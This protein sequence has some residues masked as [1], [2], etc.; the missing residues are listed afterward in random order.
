MARPSMEKLRYVTTEA[1]LQALEQMAGDPA[2]LRAL[3]HDW[4]P[5]ADDTMRER[6]GR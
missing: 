3:A 2:S 6:S 1:A 4:F 5:D